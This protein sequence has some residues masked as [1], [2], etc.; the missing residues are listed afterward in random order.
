MLCDAATA[1]FTIKET[2][3][4]QDLFYKLSINI[5]KTLTLNTVSEKDHP[6]KMGKDFKL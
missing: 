2:I 6:K 3:F 5:H 4:I 1:K